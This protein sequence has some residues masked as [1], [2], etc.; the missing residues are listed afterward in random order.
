VT[1]PR[2]GTV[3]ADEQVYL[4][5]GVE[6]TGGAIVVTASRTRQHD[7]P[8]RVVRDY[9]VFGAD[10]TVEFTLTLSPDGKAIG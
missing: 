1:E 6:L 9:V 8:A 3:V 2:L 5:T 10:G 7:E 4:I